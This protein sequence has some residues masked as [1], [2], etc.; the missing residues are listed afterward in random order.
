MWKWI[1]CKIFGIG[2]C[3][4]CDGTVIE[5][6]ELQHLKSLNNIPNDF[7]SHDMKH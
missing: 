5:K 7:K 6:S 3:E 1:K 4:K 2:C